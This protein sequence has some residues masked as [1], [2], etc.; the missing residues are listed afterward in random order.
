MSQLDAMKLTDAIRRRLAAFALDRAFVRD[1]QLAAACRD[2]WSGPAVG[3]GL[4][5]DLWVEGAFPA[6]ASAFS[7]NGLAAEGAFDSELCRHLERVGAVPAGRRL[8]AH[9]EQAIRTARDGGS[10]DRP[11]LVV[12]A[13]TG[14]G[15]TESFLLP[16][17]NDLYSEPRIP[18]EA[19]VRCLILYPM[20]AL[21]NDQVE[22]LDAWLAEQA[23][24]TLFHFTSETPED[25]KRLHKLGLPEGGRQRV[26]TRQQ[27]R[28]LESAQGK[29]IEPLDRGPVP[30]LLVTNYSML[31]YMLCR[32]QDGVFFGP[33]LRAVVLD[34]AHLYAGTLAAE[35]MLLLRRVLDR[36]GKKSG[37]VLQIAT[38][39]TLGSSQADLVQFASR[40]FSKPELRVLPIRGE[41]ARPSLAEPLPPATEPTPEAVNALR[42]LEYP[43]LTADPDGQ[44]RLSTI[45]AAAADRLRQDLSALTEPP[46]VNGSTTELRPARI[47]WDAL[48][49]TPL[50]AWLEDRLFQVRQTSLADLSRNLWQRVDNDAE[51]ATLTLLK[52]AGAARDAKSGTD[53]VTGPL[54]GHRLH[55]VTRSAAG[56]AVCLNPD[57]TGPAAHRWDGFGCLTA[58]PREV[59]PHCRSGLLA[60]CRCDNCGRAAVVGVER[61]G[62]YVP[63]AWDFSGRPQSGSRVL[64]LAD[65]ADGN[66]E[67]DLLVLDRGGEPGGHGAAGIR[68]RIVDG[69]PDCGE[70]AQTWQALFLPDRLALSIL[71]ETTLAGLPRFPGYTADWLPA[72]GRRLLAFSDSRRAAAR[73]GAAL[74][75]DH[76]TQLI[77]S[78]LARCRTGADPA[79][80]DIYR[81]DEQELLSKL[82]AEN[83]NDAVRRRYESK[84][85]E[86]RRDLSGAEAGGR[87]DEWHAAAQQLVAAKELRD[88][89]AAE[90][91]PVRATERKT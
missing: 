34:E 81:Q 53:E 22:R 61:G 7:L 42:W 38:S 9:Q 2:L 58:E 71:A 30:D 12:T 89:E 11:A 91:Q 52:L 43:T 13:G 70:D 37:D 86:V 17:L 25:R 87:L 20:N 10:D 1:E 77:R 48:R 44:Q 31:E 82:T 62:C 90:K 15:K 69:C 60:V 80:L 24:L 14:A 56:V 39:A 83:L 36:C 84:L 67:G 85:A 45:G 51:R 76:E 49:Q 33:A 40:I 64:R 57:C 6:T 88:D 50:V 19:G 79:L 47:L 72:G 54:L 46:A 16:V 5:N 21:V 26:L 3:G 29:R 18:G 65:D 75:D 63:P 27:A 73:L 28:G 35:I 23:R 59:C 78:L 8:F 41:R 68:L 66:A 4:V 32:P 74:T 55:V